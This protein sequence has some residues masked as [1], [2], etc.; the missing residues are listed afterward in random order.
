LALTGA[1]GSTTFGAVA[2]LYEADNLTGNIY[3]TTPAGVRTTFAS[4]FSP[5]GVQTISFRKL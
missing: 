5:T 1:Y 2:D 3:E 4:G